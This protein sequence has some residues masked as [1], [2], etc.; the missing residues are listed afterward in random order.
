MNDKKKGC[1]KTAIHCLLI[2]LA[3]AGI[4]RFFKIQYINVAS[5]SF[6]WE[7]IMENDIH[8]GEYTFTPDSGTLS[9]T[10]TITRD[11]FWGI[12]F[13]FKKEQVAPEAA[14]SIKVEDGRGNSVYQSTIPIS[15]IGYEGPL[16]IVFDHIEQNAKGKI[17]KL[18]VEA[19]G[20]KENDTFKI[21][22]NDKD[23]YQGGV[24][25]DASG[26]LKGNIKI[27]QNYGQCGY[28]NK[29]FWILATAITILVYA[30]YYAL[31]I[32]K[33]K[34]EYLFLCMIFITGFLYVFI[35]P[36][37]AV[38]DEAAHYRSAY[39]YANE[40]LRE[41][42]G[43]PNPVVF[44]DED[45]NYYCRIQDTSP[46]AFS[47]KELIEQFGKKATSIE[48]KEKGKPS[49]S[50]PGFMF[51]GG[52][53]GITLGR[54]LGL[55]ALTVFYLGRIFNLLLFC[56]M[57]YWAFKKLPFY[58]MSLFAICLI[59]MNVQ[60]IGSYSYD[61][62]TTGLALMLMAAVLDY[63]YGNSPGT[64]SKKLIQIAVICAL[65]G[66]CKGGAYLPLCAMVLLIPLKQFSSK[67]R[68]KLYLGGALFI[69][70]LTYI[71]LSFSRVM[72]N[73]YVGEH[74]VYWSG[75]PGYSISWV[76]S[77]PGQFVQLL[78]NTIF[79]QGDFY[80]YSLFGKDLGWFN[81]P[82]QGWIV[83]G[84]M[85]VF[86]LSAVYVAG[87]KAVIL[88]ARQKGGILICNVLSIGFIVA[89]MLFSHTPLSSDYIMGVQG[90]YL[91]PLLF[92]AVL[93]LKNNVLTL[94]HSIDR[95]L[96]FTLGW[97]QVLTIVNIVINPI[98]SLLPR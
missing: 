16:E 52:T 72:S 27:K 14:V 59:P 78:S 21:L 9:Q 32:K 33:V 35:M 22:I 29:L 94:R 70:V 74:A 83:I 86:L 50:D 13:Q 48:M 85:L 6:I 73:V 79:K 97:L 56:I 41:G 71:L 98:T 42:N 20:I 5:H 46:N 10:F 24:M 75:E 17:Y 43:I 39:A 15:E 47:Y 2:F 87:E 89:A 7:D 8:T 58:K 44:R 92:P 96:I 11:I 91:I 51:L 34:R 45:Y 53:I 3:L 76:F 36:P 90:R 40:I 60:L 64:R 18:V 1:I 4:F 57:A 31:F 19:T 62:V 88:S 37:G 23:K 77:H 80:F 63:G 30:L 54:I 69:T 25:R 82:I 67:K 65:L 81:Y 38:P 49:L 61:A 95:N 68:G 84:F 93:C 66:T 55:N 26:E 28:L 12:Q